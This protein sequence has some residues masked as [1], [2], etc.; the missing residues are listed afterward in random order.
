MSQKWIRRQC[1]R[2]IEMLCVKN[3]RFMGG[4]LLRAVKNFN[5]KSATSAR[6]GKEEEEC[7]PVAMIAEHIHRWIDEGGES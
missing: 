4:R 2:L 6:Q 3:C 1:I 5:K 7:C